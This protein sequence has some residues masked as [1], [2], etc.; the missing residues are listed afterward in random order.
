MAR[1]WCHLTRQQRH[2]IQPYPI[3][4]FLIPILR[5]IRDSVNFDAAQGE[6]EKV[7]R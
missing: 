4:F 3:H 7:E 5:L 1:I 2:T 6:T